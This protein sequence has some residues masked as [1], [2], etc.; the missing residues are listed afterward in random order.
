MI[1]IEPNKIFAVSVIGSILFLFWFVFSISNT[2]SYKVKKT[3]L[4]INI[5]LFFVPFPEF[6]N[7]YLDMLYLLFEYEPNINKGNITSLIH[8]TE[9]GI[10]YNLTIR[11]YMQIIIFCLWLVIV[12]L[13][14]VKQLQ[15]YKKIFEV[16]KNGI[17]ASPQYWENE[18]I[19]IEIKRQDIKKNISIR[20]VDSIKFPTS[21]G[22]FKPTIF[23]PKKILH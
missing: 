20:K 4:I 10:A 23:L 11:Y 6:K 13:F 21:T 18:I 15:K 16:L 3:F 17:F 8:I 7:N 12:M 14:F 2:I 19:E 5:I 22:F 1:N 9:N